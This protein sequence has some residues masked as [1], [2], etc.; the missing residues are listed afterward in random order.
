MFQWE[1]DKGDYKKCVC[2]NKDCQDGFDYGR[3]LGV[4]SK[5]GT[6]KR[7]GALNLMP[8]TQTP[9][10]CEYWQTWKEKLLDNEYVA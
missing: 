7:A 4:G 6:G 5:A 1:S 3:S 8:L 10:T 9:L 2:C